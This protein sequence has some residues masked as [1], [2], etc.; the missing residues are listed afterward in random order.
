[1][2]QCNFVYIAN[3][4]TCEFKILLKDYKV[5]YVSVS[6]NTMNLT[7]HEILQN[8]RVSWK[9]QSKKLEEFYT[10][11]WNKYTFY[12]TYARW[13][14]EQEHKW[15]VFVI[16][17]IFFPSYCWNTIS[18]KNYLKHMRKI[19]KRSNK[20]CLWNTMPRQGKKVTVKSWWPLMSTESFWLKEYAY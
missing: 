16:P 7:C 2:W 10:N 14:K 17:A 11:G 18:I 9:N 13:A 3:Q 19:L 20:A 12:L 6:G 8:Y 5:I 4:L 15:V 1:M